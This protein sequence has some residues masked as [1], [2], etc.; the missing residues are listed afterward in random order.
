MTGPSD[1]PVPAGG[2]GDAVV[3]LEPQ[4]EGRDRLTSAFRMILVVPHLIILGGFSAGVAW[5]NRGAWGGGGALA[6]AAW[7][8]AVVAWFA[9]VFTGRAPRGLWQFGAYYLR[10]S[11]RVGAY[12]ALLRDEYPPFGDDPY[13]A[14]VEVQFPDGPRDRLRVF[15]RP[16]LAIPHLVALAFIDL[17]WIFTTIAAWLAIVFSGTLPEGLARFGVGALRWNVRVQ[18]Y[19]LLL[20]DRYPPFR[21]AE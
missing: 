17:A 21:L 6:G 10:W 13:P 2:S 4:R 7:A 18:A 15:L 20:T 11:V 14:T 1:T 8:M 9:V 12:L 16:I 3:S 19:L 5:G